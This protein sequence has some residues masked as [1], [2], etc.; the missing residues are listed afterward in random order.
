MAAITT[1][2][3]VGALVVA[4][5]SAY[6]G[7]QGRKDAQQAAESAAD[8]NRKTRSEQQALNAQNAAIEQRKLIREE[9]VRRGM[10]MQ[11]S[12]NTGTGDSS[13]QLGAVG[14]LGTELGSNLGVNSG[15]IAAGNRISGYVQN[16]ADF[17]LA[18]QNA[19]NGA[20]NADQ[21]FSLA[22]SVFQGAGGLGTIKTAYGRG[23]AGA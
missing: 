11:N 17:N 3:A 16:A 9:R 22:G 5:A 1:I 12:E 8:E 10:I 18:S 13:G 15:R 2:V 6:A 7:Y 20:Q 19:A 14:G 4:G 23:F 21:L